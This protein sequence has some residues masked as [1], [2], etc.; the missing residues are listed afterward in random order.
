MAC[1]FEAMLFLLIFDAKAEITI[2]TEYHVEN[3]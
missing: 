3:D 1:K 2:V